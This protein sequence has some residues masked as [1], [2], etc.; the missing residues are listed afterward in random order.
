MQPRRLVSAAGLVAA[1]WTTLP[2]LAADSATGW[3]QHFPAGWDGRGAGGGLAIVPAVVWWL[4]V[5]GWMRS[6]EW[7]GR[8]AT[9]H[10]FTPAFWGMVCGVPLFVAATLAWWIP[11]VLAG[12]GLMLVAWLA[13]VITY[14]L[15]RNAKLPASERVLTVGHAR[16]LL[17]GAVAPLGIEIDAGSE[18]GDLVPQVTLAAAGGKDAAEN[19]ARVEAAT[20]LPGFEEARKTLL[21][22]VMARAAT[23]VIDCEPA[24]MG[25]RHEV[26]GVWEKPKIRQPPKSRKEKESWVEAPKSSLEVGQ[27]VVAALKTLCGLPAAA[28]EAKSAPFLLQVDGKPR[29]C[30]LTVR[31]RT[32][33]EQVSIQID[34]PAAVFKKLTDLGMPA[35]V[36]EQA[37]GLTAFEKGLIIVSAPE[38]SGLTTT[39]DLLVQSADRLLRD[40]ISLEDAA[41]PP[42]EIQNVRPVP[43]D[44]RTGVTPLEALEGVLR[45]YPNVIVT[46]D[47]RDKALVAKLAELADDDK[48]VIMSLKASDAI[49]AVA[50]VL[51]CG[52]PPQT[53]AKTLVGSLSQRLLRRLC[54]KC[55]EDYP[56]EPEPLPPALAKRNLTAEQRGLL[57]RPSPDGCRLCGGTGYLGRAAIFELAS[58][59]TVRKA[60]AGGADAATLRKAAAQ[61]G[62]KPLRDAGLALVL[63]GVTSLDELQRVFA[64]AG[65]P[66]AAPPAAAKGATKK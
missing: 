26:D 39:F 66:P 9:K 60:V 65:S 62:M 61:D 49:D 12:I 59:P 50:R 64:P 47:V 51:A 16:R 53:L 20:A 4:C 43:F 37:V 31:R 23:L 63:E 28:K 40:F 21:A 42:R 33:G 30:R 44:A 25:V 46:R 35:P 54:P 22:A 3:P 48:F 36:A 2:A 29:N 24:G 7:V 10:K 41:A 34:A 1:A 19:A 17:A 56:A 45:S 13:P 38:G 52:V 8:D 6:V 18:A 58:G 32:E 5:L 14:A 57:K 27:A 55:R 11:S 15:F